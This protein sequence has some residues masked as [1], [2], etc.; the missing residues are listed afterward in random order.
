MACG[1]G[2]AAQRLVTDFPE[3]PARGARPATIDEV[4][5]RAGVSKSTVSKLLNGVP[6]VS[7][8][9]ALRIREAI[10]ELDFRPNQLARSLA[11]LEPLS[12]AAALS[13]K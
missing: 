9:A 3:A 5:R 1:S 6:Y 2:A 4:A 11:T 13:T 8:Q 7:D 12:A 10:T